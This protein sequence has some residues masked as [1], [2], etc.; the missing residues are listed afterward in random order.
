MRKEGVR[1]YGTPEHL[2][3][4]P[5]ESVT[6]RNPQPFWC[7]GVH[8]MSLNATSDALFPTSYDEMEIIWLAFLLKFWVG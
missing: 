6:L 2:I 5:R 7:F 1:I 3:I 4:F 8:N